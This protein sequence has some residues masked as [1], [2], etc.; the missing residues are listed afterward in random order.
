MTGTEPIMNLYPIN[1]LPADDLAVRVG[2]DVFILGYP[3]VRHRRHFPCGSA[4][5]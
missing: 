4:A 2:M 1:T 5:A 3:L